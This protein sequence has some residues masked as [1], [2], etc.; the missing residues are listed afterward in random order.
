MVEEGLM[1]IRADQRGRTLSKE[2]QVIQEVYQ[3]KK[4]LFIYFTQTL[5]KLQPVAE[6]QLVTAICTCE[7]AKEKA[8]TEADVQECIKK[9][10]ATNFLKRQQQRYT[11]THK[12]KSW[13]KQNDLGHTFR[14]A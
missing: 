4:D 13:L 1:K 8:W 14:K 5:Y 3:E 12:L 2:F 11:S 6:Q 10:E 9:L 7:I